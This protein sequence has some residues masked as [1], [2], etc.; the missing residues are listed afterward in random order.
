[1]RQF[2]KLRYLLVGSVALM[3][4]L[5][6]LMLWGNAY[7]LDFLYL[8][9]AGAP[10]IMH[11]IASYSLMKKYYPDSQIP[12]SFIITFNIVSVFAWIAWV[13]LAI[14]LLSMLTMLVENIS[15]LP[16]WNALAIVILGN[17]GL[18][19]SIMP[20][21]FI[22]GYRVLSVIQENHKKNLLKT[23]E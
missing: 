8:F 11:I 5:C 3:A 4:C 23:F 2:K 6:G 10:N 22:T 14:V 16:N 21:Q 17:F 12:R 19:I 7:R 15:N 1:M 13:G 9:I 18:L 20:F